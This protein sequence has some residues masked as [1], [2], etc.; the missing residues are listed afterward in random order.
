MAP[1]ISRL[2]FTM[3][4]T[5]FL[6]ALMALPSLTPGS[7]AFVVDVMAL[8]ISGGFLVLLVWSIRR[9]IAR[10]IPSHDHH[11]EDSNDSPRPSS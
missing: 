8:L 6:L 4:L 11:K 5:L 10:R 9:A 1:A 7:P 3:G 2:A